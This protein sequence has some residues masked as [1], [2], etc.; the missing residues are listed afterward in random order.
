MPGPWD[1]E[2]Q[3]AG[4]PGPTGSWG[5]ARR[6]LLGS[7]DIFCLRRHSDNRKIHFGLSKHGHLGWPLAPPLCGQDLGG[8]CAQA[9]IQDPGWA[10]ASPRAQA[11]QASTPVVL[12]ALPLHCDP[13][14]LRLEPPTTCVSGV[15][16]P[17]P[18]GRPAA[19]QPPLTPRALGSSAWPSCLLLTWGC[20]EGSSVPAPP[21]PM[22]PLHGALGPPSRPRV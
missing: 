22:L 2:N 6:T 13:A 8:P 7:W 9:T 3:G 12:P 15:S 10:L 20:S 1:S 5:Q 16:P 14:P 11:L 17:P 21:G 19:G 4:G 18:C